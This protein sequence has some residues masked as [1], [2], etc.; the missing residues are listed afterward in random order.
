MVVPLPL[1][2]VEVAKG[3]PRVTPLV[4]VEWIPLHFRIVGTKAPRLHIGTAPYTVEDVVHNA[5]VADIA[6][7]L[8]IW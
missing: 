7:N 4:C 5:V 3:G 1:L 2:L 6:Q 8:V